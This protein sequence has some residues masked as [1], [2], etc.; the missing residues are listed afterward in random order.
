MT[1][2]VLQGHIY[3]KQKNNTMMEIC[4][5]VLLLFLIYLYFGQNL[6]PGF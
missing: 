2:F 4:L 5:L 1:A 6:Y 3:K